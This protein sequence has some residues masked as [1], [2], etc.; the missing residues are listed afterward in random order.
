M[1]KDKI[2]D[3]IPLYFPTLPGI[4]GENLSQTDWLLLAYS[5]SDMSR[6]LPSQLSLVAHD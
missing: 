3:K 5:T 2:G 1:L 6:P 4:L